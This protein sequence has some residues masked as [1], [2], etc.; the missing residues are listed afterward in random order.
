MQAAGAIPAV[1]FH[2]PEAWRLARPM[3]IACINTFSC[4]CP[5]LAD[6]G[7]ANAD[8]Q[9]ALEANCPSVPIALHA[10]R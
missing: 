2:V 9:A 10:S 1:F 8:N 6:S 7:L 4:V 5:L 3:H